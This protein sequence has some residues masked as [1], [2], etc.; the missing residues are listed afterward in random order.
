ML[1]ETSVA[2]D[3]LIQ[4]FHLNRHAPSVRS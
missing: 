1:T 4:V 2:Q 3:K